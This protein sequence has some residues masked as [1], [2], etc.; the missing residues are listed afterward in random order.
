MRGNKQ[1]EKLDIQSRI[2][3]N[4]DWYR[5]AKRALSE[6]E[7]EFG[8]EE[9]RLRFLAD[10]W[11]L[12]EDA[13]RNDPGL[14]TSYYGAMRTSFS[15]FSSRDP[16]DPTQ[17]WDDPIT[18]LTSYLYHTGTTSGSTLLWQKGDPR[19][20]DLA[21]LAEKP[22]RERERRERAKTRL[23][24]ISPDLADK[25]SNAWDLF[26]GSSEGDP[27]QPVVYAMREVITHTVN[28]LSAPGQ[29]FHAETRPEERMTRI[30]WIA[31]N[32]VKSPSSRKRVTEAATVYNRVYGKLSRVGHKRKGLPGWIVKEH[33]LQAQDLLLLILESID[34]TTIESNASESMG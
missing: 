33:L 31:V 23:H 28:H 25:F 5:E 7:I 8:E 17:W 18:N 10:N 29:P 12:I 9:E 16:H 11:P 24:Q 21:K 26:Y 14:Q 22:R 1:H 32:L 20:Q 27:L 4:A 34:S 30:Q 13:I 6:K 19:W 15:W 2:R 3:S